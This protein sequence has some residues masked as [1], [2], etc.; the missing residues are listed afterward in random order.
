MYIYVDKCNGKCI[1][2][3]WDITKYSSKCITAWDCGWNTNYTIR[4]QE[5]KSIAQWSMKS[6]KRKTDAC[7]I[8]C[9]GSNMKTKHFIS[10]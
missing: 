4:L 3:S 2:N 9:S 5:E 7:W 6:E 1:R 8:K 10:L